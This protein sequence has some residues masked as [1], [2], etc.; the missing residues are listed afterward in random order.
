MKGRKGGREK[1]GQRE[2]GRDERREGGREKIR[3]KRGD[4]KRK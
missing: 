4:E 3:E 1:R 2:G